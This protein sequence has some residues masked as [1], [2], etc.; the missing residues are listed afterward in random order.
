MMRAYHKK[1]KNFQTIKN[2]R[3]VNIRIEEATLDTGYSSGAT[4][5][6][7]EKQNIT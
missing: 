5:K 4:Y 6:Y 1:V 7:L 3:E 2:M